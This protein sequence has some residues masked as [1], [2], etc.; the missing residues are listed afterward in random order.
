MSVYVVRAFVKLHEVWRATRN[1]RRSWMIWNGSSLDGL[2]CT[3]KLFCNYLRRLE[4]CCGLR[5][6]SRSQSA[7]ALAF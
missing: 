5:P 2:M 6:L 3:R 7:D 1:W 4:S